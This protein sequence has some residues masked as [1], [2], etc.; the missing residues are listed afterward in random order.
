MASGPGWLPRV[1]STAS[2]L[3]SFSLP[4]DS[5]IPSSISLSVPTPRNLRGGTSKAEKSAVGKAGAEVAGSRC[6]WCNRTSPGEGGWVYKW[7]KMDSEDR[8][9]SASKVCQSCALT[10]KEKGRFDPKKLPKDPTLSTRKLKAAFTQASA[11]ISR[12]WNSTS[13]ELKEAYNHDDKKAALGWLS[14]LEAQPVT[15]EMLESTQI[16]KRM[17][18]WMRIPIEEISLK[19]RNLLE[20][21]RERV[22]NKRQGPRLLVKLGGRQLSLIDLL[23]R[24][25][26]G[27]SSSDDHNVY[28]RGIT[29]R[30]GAEIKPKGSKLKYPE[31]LETN[32]EEEKKFAR[33]AEQASEP[34]NLMEDTSTIST[35]KDLTTHSQDEWDI[36][37]GAK[38]DAQMDSE[39]RYESSEDRMRVFRPT[40]N[41][42]RNKVIQRLA[43]CMQ[44]GYD[45]DYPNITSRVP[46]PGCE[47]EYSSRRSLR[48]AYRT[49]RRIYKRNKNVVDFAYFGHFHQIL[50]VLF[51]PLNRGAILIKV[52]T[53]EVTLGDLCRLRPRELRAENIKKR[54]RWWFKWLKYQLPDM[55]KYTSESDSGG[56][57]DNP[58]NYYIT[59]HTCGKCGQRRSKILGQLQT[60]SADE[61]MTTFYQCI[62]GQRFRI[63]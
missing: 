38:E 58:S 30:T 35:F 50:S 13:G 34:R 61:G 15:L 63:S 42:L 37:R 1:M 28:I 14:N 52:R 17:K 60:R 11:V 62:C 25:S 22:V 18:T 3:L 16:L 24:Q 7:W 9:I 53:G 2:L 6:G 23:P 36:Y 41:G 56:A 32:H 31:I 29:S 19:A 33:L 5:R 21:W 48:F 12:I 39:F 45:P 27:S 40:E 47:G 46:Y 51:H 43:V 59:E 44:L 26:E 57:E 10:F 8:Q 54:D 4:R 55:R 49:E 20:R